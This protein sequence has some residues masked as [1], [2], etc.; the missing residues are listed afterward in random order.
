MRSFLYSTASAVALALLLGACVQEGSA[1]ATA[2]A[3]QPAKPGTTKA[4]SGPFASVE[5]LTCRGYY[6]QSEA[7]AGHLN[8]P[9]SAFRNSKVENGKFTMLAAKAEPGVSKGWE[10]AS[11]NWYM[12]QGSTGFDLQKDGTWHFKN[13]VA[14]SNY[15]LTPV[16]SDDPAVKKFTV[17]YVDED[18]KGWAGGKAECR[19]K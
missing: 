18:A 12:N 2:T 19:S 14:G 6:K 16:A 9:E 11:G 3:L 15:Y 8:R 1:P 13:T 10:T 5:G 4:A 17:R 7:G